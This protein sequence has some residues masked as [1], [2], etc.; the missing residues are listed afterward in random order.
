[1][2]LSNNFLLEELVNPV[3][4]ERCGSRCKDFLNPN[5]VPTLEAIR[6]LL[7]D[8]I[9]VNDWLWGGRYVDSG[10]R[11]PGGDVG[12]SLSPHKFGTAADLK[13]KAT[14]IQKGFDM[15]I[16]NQS[17]FPYIS[18]MEHSDATPSWIHVEVSTDKRSGNIYVF[19]P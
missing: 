1:M 17:M 15:I 2:K 11:V 10:L 5:L 9:T 8:G 4:F 14:D 18:R 12:A 16:A 19:K 3:I 13:F 6:T 7:D